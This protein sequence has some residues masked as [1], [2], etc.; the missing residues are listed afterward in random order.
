MSCTYNILHII[1]FY[2]VIY[3]YIYIVAGLVGIY[4]VCIAKLYLDAY[5]AV[6]YVHNNNNI[7]HY[8]L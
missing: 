4:I 3:T 1:I 7:T 5:L 6:S 8:K 2:Y